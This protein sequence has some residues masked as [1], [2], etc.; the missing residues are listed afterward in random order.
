MRKQLLKAL[1]LTLILTT[2]AW[3]QVSRGTIL[4]TVKDPSGAVIPGVSVTI[5]NEGTNLSRSLIT[6]ETGSFNAELLP[7]GKYRVEAELAGFRKEVRTG[8][9]LHIDQKARADMTL[10]VGDVVLQGA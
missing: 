4:G 10:Q 6:D 7:I 5:V 8:I 9:E 3:S 1:L 2:S